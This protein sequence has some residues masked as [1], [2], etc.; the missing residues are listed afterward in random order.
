MQ[1]CRHSHVIYV[2]NIVKQCSQPPTY[3]ITYYSLMTL[4][5][6]TTLLMNDSRLYSVSY[7]CE[8]QSSS[9]PSMIAFALRLAAFVDWPPG[10]DDESPDVWSVNRSRSWSVPID[11]RLWL[12]SLITVLAMLSLNFCSLE[13]HSANDLWWKLFNVIFNNNIDWLKSSSVLVVVASYYTADNITLDQAV[14]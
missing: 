13:S 1:Q 12:S 10:F 8:S 11:V 2:D 14:Q 7:C 4:F 9:I 5:P 3:Y 6:R